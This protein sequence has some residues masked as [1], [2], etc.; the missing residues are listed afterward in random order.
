M[1]DGGILEHH[2]LSSVSSGNSY[3]RNAWE[4][5]RSKSIEK[6]EYILKGGSVLTPR[7]LLLEDCS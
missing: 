5:T 1:E 2:D 6:D 3:L 7:R 4:W